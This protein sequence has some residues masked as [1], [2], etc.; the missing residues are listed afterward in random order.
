MCCPLSTI[1]PVSRSVNAV[2]RPPSRLFASSTSTRA[3]RLARRTAALNPANPAPMT[4]T[5]GAVTVIL[6]APQPLPER[7]QR[8]PR[9]RHPRPR[10]EHVVPAAFDALQRFEIHRSHDLGR[11]QP[12]A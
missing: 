8:L 9:L 2:A 5:S 10:G 6:S 7:N 3:P 11:D 1:S 4:I 12:P